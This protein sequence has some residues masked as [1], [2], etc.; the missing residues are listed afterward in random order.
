MKLSTNDILSE[1]VSLADKERLD[2]I[3]FYLIDRSSSDLIS[4]I[5]DLMSVAIDYTSSC[6]EAIWLH[7]M[8]NGQHPDAFDRLNVPSFSAAIKGLALID[9][10]TDKSKLCDTCAYRAGTLGNHSETTQSDVET[11]MAN[12]AVFYCHND[13]TSTVRMKACQ[14]YVQHRKELEL[15]Q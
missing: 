3:R 8:C 14:G 10:A 4:V 13:Q 11:A 7:L 15:E 2:F 6:D 12:G 1:A 5:S 9:I